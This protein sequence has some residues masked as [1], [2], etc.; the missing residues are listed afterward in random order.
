VKVEN[1]A[2][3][4]DSDT[5]VLFIK[6][7]PEV[8]VTP[9]LASDCDS[10]SL[11]VDTVAGATYFWLGPN[12]TG[13]PTNQPT[14]T[15][16]QSG[17]YYPTVTLDGCVGR[18]T[19]VISILP[20]PAVDL[21]P[22]QQTCDTVNLDA[23]PG[24]SYLWSTGATTQT[25]VVP[26]AAATQTISVV[27]TDA[28]GCQGSD[29]VVINQA[30]P[31]IV[32]LGP[33]RRE[34]GQVTLNAGNPGQ[35]F[36]WSTGAT[37]QTI[38]ATQSGSYHVLVT[39]QFNCTDT[40]TVN[41]DIL[42]LPM[43]SASF[44]GPV[45]GQTVT[46]LNNSSPAT[47]VSYQWNFGDGSPIDTSAEPVH[48]YFV[49]GSFV[50]TLVV[51]NDCGRDTTTLFIQNIVAGLNDNWFEQGLEVYP[52]PSNGLFYLSA[53]HLEPD[54]LQIEIT[55]ARGR[56]VLKRTMR[57]AGGSLNE[58][59]DLSGMSEGLYLLQV[60]GREGSGTQ[61]LQVK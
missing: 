13:Q 60:T 7:R 16:T 22:N 4:T 3:C 54:E 29:Q 30:N 14:F 8:D 9:G 19:A 1:S 41:V 20:G 43:A 17:N 39:N 61:R 21:G 5:I 36:T 11:A 55:D 50:V 18:D 35:A 34:C 48:T 51:I 12:P 45:N 38:T 24:V 23:G 10:V 46:F 15:A 58:T 27:V 40:D 37:T 33:D 6:P 28:S 44:T 2:G 57:H 32:N 59:L 47:G 52:N 49:S 26:P 53:D 56:T 42:P 31:P 25:L